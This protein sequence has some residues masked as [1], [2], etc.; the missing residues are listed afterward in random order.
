MKLTLT[1][2]TL[3]SFLLVLFIPDF[4]LAETK[5][6]IKEYTFHAGDED[7]KNSSR[8]V[9]LREVKRLLLEELGTYLESETEVQDF[10]L[11]KDQI[12][13]LTAGI[14][15]TKLV[16]ETWDGRTY[17]IK[18]KIAADSEGVIKSIDSLRKNRVKTKELAE[19]RKRS[20]SLLKEN[21][22]LR[23][24]LTML[25]GKKKQKNTMAYNKTIRDLNAVEWFER[26]YAAGISGN[27]NDAVDAYSKAIE[28][29]PQ[30]VEAYNNRG[31]IYASLGNHNQAI[32]DFNKTIELD[33]QYAYA[34][35]NRGAAYKILG[36]FK[37][38]IDDHNK[39][40]ELNPQNA[41]SYYNRGLTYVSLG[42]Y[43]QAINDFDKAIELNP[44]YEDGYNNRAYLLYER[45]D[46]KR[47]LNDYNLLLSINPN[48]ARAYMGR[49]FVCS[50]TGNLNQMV[51]DI[52]MAC[53]L[54]LVEA[55]KIDKIRR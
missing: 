21:E 5:T 30:Y 23:Q 8:T 18:A 42:N 9:A 32:K 6:F 1:R 39:A 12:T 38:A 3:V 51:A 43:D 41:T 50:A 25:K 34:Y 48:Y 44:Q 10:Q 31:N 37:Q 36:D 49:A 33:P 19:V 17:W 55:C 4:T 46:Y 7:S 27:A 26:G 20:D 40:I 13:T 28:V 14:V 15:K 16:E 52:K 47:A 29:N 24:E 35:S 54:G 22:R 53:D 2:I 11:T 45:K